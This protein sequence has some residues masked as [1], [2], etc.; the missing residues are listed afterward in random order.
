V[1]IKL[2][3]QRKGIIKQEELIYILFDVYCRH[4]LQKRAIGFL[5]AGIKNISNHLKKI[6]LCKLDGC[7]KIKHILSKN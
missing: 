7:C 6:Y 5:F 2:S 3:R 4:G 1:P